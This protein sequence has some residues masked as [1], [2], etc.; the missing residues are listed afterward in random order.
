MRKIS[1]LLLVSLF[2]FS[3]NTVY[4]QVEKCTIK[5]KVIEEETR[6]PIEGVTVEVKSSHH[7][8]GYFKESTDRNGRF[9][10]AGIPAGTRYNLVAYKK[11]YCD[12]ELNSWEIAPYLQSIELL[13]PMIRA[14]ELTGKVTTSSGLPI[15]DAQVR[16]EQTERRRNTKTAYTE[17]NGSYRFP[18][19]LPS[20]YDIRIEHS[21]Y[22]YETITNIE[23][24]SGDRKQQNITLYKPASISGTVMIEELGQA[25]R[26]ITVTARGPRPMT[27]VTAHDGSYY[28]G[29]LKP[30]EYLIESS[31]EGIHHYRM[32]KTVKVSEGEDKK[33]A[34]FSVKLKPPEMHLV[35]NRRVFLP[36]EGISFDIRT[37]RTSEP[38]ITIYRVPTDLILSNRWKEETDTRRFEGFEKIKGWKSQV[39]NFHPYR[40]I[41][42]TVSIDERLKEGVYVVDISSGNASSREVIYVTTLGI[43]CKRD[44]EKILVYAT[45]LKENRPIAGV[46]IHLIPEKETDWKKLMGHTLREGILTGENGT[47]SVTGDQN[48]DYMVVG[49]SSDGSVA[50]TRAWLPSSFKREREKIYIYTDRPVYRPSHRVCFK[51]ILRD[52][53]ADKPAVAPGEKVNTTIKNPDGE[54]VYS[55]TLT[56]NRFGSVNGFFDIPDDA[57]LGQYWIEMSGSGRDTQYFTVEEY[58]KPEFK[59]EVETDKSFYTSG[60]QIDFKIN[61]EYYFGAPVVASK[62]RYRIYETKINLDEC[63]YWWERNYAGGGYTRLARSGETRTDMKGLAGLTYTPS[64]LPYDR[65]I[66]IEV[67]ITDPS[68]RVV[69]GKKTTIMGRGEFYIKVRQDKYIYSQKDW[70]SVIIGTFDFSDR[71]VSRKVNVQIL[72]DVWNPIF[73]TYTTP[74]RPIATAVV[75]TDSNGWGSVRF[76][77]IKESTGRMQI[78]CRAVDDRGNNISTSSYMWV[79]GGYD[80]TYSYNYQG[81]ELILNKDE[82]REGETAELI[83][84]SIY[85]E[86]FFMLTVEGKRIFD[87]QVSRFNGNTRILKIP[88]KREYAPQVDIRV[89]SQHGKDLITRSASIR[90]PVEGKKMDIKVTAD[91]DKYHPGEKGTFHIYATDE[92]KKPVSTELS[93]AVVDEAIFSIRPDHTPDIYDYFYL[94]PARWVHTSYSYPI[95]YRAGASKEGHPP[96][97]KDFKDTALWLADVLTDSNG[98]A[99]VQ[100]EYPDNLT[101]WRATV[102]G[103]TEDTLVGSKRIKTLV[104]KEIISRLELPRFFVEGDSVK[105][106]GVVNNNTN[107]DMKRVT[108]ELKTDKVIKS[109]SSRRQYLDIPAGSSNKSYW[110]IK[111]LPGKEEAELTLTARGK[112]YSDAVLLKAPVIPFGVS[113]PVVESGGFSEK[114]KIVKISPPDAGRYEVKDM[115]VGISPSLAGMSISSLEYL[116]TYPYGCIE[117]VINSFLPAMHLLRFFKDM[118][119]EKPGFDAGIEKRMSAGLQKIY[120]AQNSDGGWGWW[121]KGETNYYITAYAVYCLYLAKE[122]GY[123]VDMDRYKRGV[124]ALKEFLH[125]THSSDMEA[126]IL[127]I[128]SEIGEKDRVIAEELYSNLDRLNSFGYACLA[129]TMQKYGESEKAQKALK[130]LLGKM[131][132]KKESAYW[133]PAYGQKWGWPG[134]QAEITARGLTALLRCGYNGK[135]IDKIIRYL[136]DSRIG[137]RWGSTKETATVIMALSEYLKKYGREETTPDYTL[138]IYVNNILIK[139]IPVRSDNISEMESLHLVVPQEKLKAGENTIRFVKEGKGRVYYSVKLNGLVTGKEIEARDYQE[140]MKIQKEYL[141]ASIVRDHRGNPYIMSQPIGEGEVLK[142]G[143]EIMVRITI[144]SSLPFEYMNME[145][146]LPSGFEVSREDTNIGGNYH[147]QPYTYKERRDEKMVYFFS[148]LNKGKTEVSYLL[149]A[150]L[151]GEF[152]VMPTYVSAMYSPDIFAYTDSSSI[153]VGE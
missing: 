87:C 54:I 42:N 139:T 55:K 45:H 112:K 74:S 92:N 107:E 31:S 122:Y 94:K 117:Q 65:N 24:K 23:L 73:H 3:V 26:G 85:P 70:I 129:L 111:V 66:T 27:A 144:E 20:R 29:D 105:V 113:Y 104:T 18:D 124:D 62:V 36:E 145:D 52:A 114:E 75:E 84:N 33:G 7:G 125:K 21:A 116:A 14:A 9:T 43:V 126:Y 152:R 2:Y 146:I 8:P 61:A 71:P 97:R 49:I 58:R 123:T 22:S 30:G 57:R 149:R 133:E 88:V 106:V 103:N 38:D 25:A 90:V 134:G 12:Y 10:F 137:N 51:G 109:L 98:K 81:M 76:Q 121:G 41:Y 68:N 59:V 63:T 91:R 44:S 53:T 17:K 153:T 67:E 40:W 35:I 150:E 127:F 1:I 95:I 32:K 64:R 142:P 96:I 140:E 34:D 60:E 11:D 5:G 147:W 79:Y 46:N 102:I 78:N 151:P 100:V 118:G 80:A 72:Q 143:D 13:L 131:V 128:L 37:F 86:D 115:E 48:T 50:I 15:P 4:A 56:T 148:H 93:I 136:A 99:S 77:Q 19:L 135:E 39:K 89:S 130:L 120:Q 47:A 6:K 119:M 82:Y 138:N 83:V 16:I 132:E 141:K 28:A 101:T 108:A 110:K 69:S